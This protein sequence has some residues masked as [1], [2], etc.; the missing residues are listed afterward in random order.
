[1]DGAPI[2]T[3]KS[4]LITSIGTQQK[5]VPSHLNPDR[6]GVQMASHYANTIPPAVIPSCD[7]SVWEPGTGPVVA[8]YNAATIIFDGAATTI[9]VAN[10]NADG[11]AATS[12]S[13]PISNEIGGRYGF[14]VGLAG[15]ASPWYVI[16]TNIAVP[17]T[18][19]AENVQTIVPASN[20]TAGDASASNGAYVEL[21]VNR[22]S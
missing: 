4:I 10:L 16:T 14:D 20:G 19:E 6:M 17:E 5:T 11:T 9:S 13:V 2:A 1:M 12:I 8:E 21:D 18:V 15:D 22:I 3:S 7:I